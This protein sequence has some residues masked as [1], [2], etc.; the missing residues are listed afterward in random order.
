M[1]NRK[2]IFSK[3]IASITFGCASI[4]NFTK[5]LPN[6]HCSLLILLIDECTRVFFQNSKF[7]GALTHDKIFE[8]AL[9]PVQVHPRATLCPKENF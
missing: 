1:P 9:N 5:V 3:N 6:L 2:N 7:Y 4:S 8:I